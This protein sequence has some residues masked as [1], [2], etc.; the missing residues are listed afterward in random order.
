MSRW[1]KARDDL[2]IDID[3]IYRINVISQ[4]SPKG[5]ITYAIE[6]SY[7]NVFNP[8]GMV[9]Q[10]M[11]EIISDKFNSLEEADHYIEEFL[12]GKDLDGMR[13]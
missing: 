9:S 13:T 1:V 3:K 12:A 5:Q 7:I 6:V 2:W 10:P 11:K 8:E 4:F